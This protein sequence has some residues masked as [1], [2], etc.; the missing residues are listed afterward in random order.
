VVRGNSPTKIFV[1]VGVAFLCLAVATAIATAVSVAANDVACEVFSL[2]HCEAEAAAEA[3]KPLM[4][5][6]KSMR[7]K[8]DEAQNR[9]IVFGDSDSLKRVAKVLSE[10]DQTTEERKSSEKTPPTSIPDFNA[11]EMTDAQ[12]RQAIVAL[13][14]LVRELTLRVQR[15]EEAQKLRVIP[16]ESRVLQPT[17]Q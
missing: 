8:I 12:M 9:L 15:L 3:L 2:R 5:S 1:V 11:E 17:A 14:N 16:L 4:A 13:S 10:L 6:Q 7:I